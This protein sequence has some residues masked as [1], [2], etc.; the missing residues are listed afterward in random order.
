MAYLDALSGSALG[1]RYE[2]S[3]LETILGRHPD[4]HVVLDSGAVSRQH[5]K[6]VR[7]GTRYL[8]ED[9]KSRNGTFINGKLIGEA[10]ALQDGDVIRICDLELAYHGDL[11]PAQVDQLRLDG[12]SMGIMLYE[13]PDGLP[14]SSITAKM[15]VKGGTHGTQ[16]GAGPEIKLNA[17]IDIMQALGKAVSLDDVLPKV[18]D[19]LFRIFIQ[20]DRGFI[21]LK[22]AQGN[23]QPRWIKTRRPDQEE[24]VR[25]SKTVLKTVMENKEAIISLDAGSDERFNMSQSLAD[26]RI[27]S[28]IIA[29]LLS[30]EGEALGAIQI[31]TIQ[32][33]GRFEPKDL[34]VLI[35]VANQSGIA[36]ENAQLHEQMV[37]QRLVEQDLELAS[38]VQKAF[39][40]SLP[41]TLDKYSFYQYYNPANQIGGDYFDYITLENDR[42]AIVVAD[43]VGHGVAAAMFMAKLSAETRYAFASEGDPSKAMHLLNERLTS[44]NVERFVT[45]LVIII[46]SKG[47]RAV[48]VNAGHMPPI[49]R[50]ANGETIEP[51]V[52]TSGPPLAI[53]QGI[54]YETCSVDIRSGDTLALYTDGIFE[55]PNAAGEQFSIARIRKHLA[56]AEK[57]VEKIGKTLIQDVERH[58]H[59]LTQEDDMCLVVFRKT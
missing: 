30:I 21:I 15:E 54:E 16:I 42:L 58:I 36:I 40:P 11:E 52:E 50:R 8:L 19:S 4:C 28:M 53:M 22:D 5:A 47:E 31:D 49:L 37:A 12:S 26:F 46:E 57:T 29:P 1:K 33:K 24:M 6:I 3:R 2:L 51:G 48:I 44:L 20:A 55:A 38:Q 10:T 9:L 14:T 7:D 27:R 39:L 43:V 25:V 59:G 34:E 41:P 56:Q 45:M 23:L 18:L 13:E 35:A 17:M 32:H